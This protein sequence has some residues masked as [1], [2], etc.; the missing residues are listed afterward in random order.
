MFFMFFLKVKGELENIQLV[1][2]I[3]TVILG[4]TEI[5]RFKVW[6]LKLL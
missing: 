5:D 2:D 3:I 1:C 4:Y 6:I